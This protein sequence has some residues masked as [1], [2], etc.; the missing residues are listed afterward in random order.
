LLLSELTAAAR[1][2]GLDL[3]TTLAAAEAALPDPEEQAMLPSLPQGAG[4]AE[5]AALPPNHLRTLI[6]QLG[7]EQRRHLAGTPFTSRLELGGGLLRLFLRHEH[8][9]AQLSR[10]EQP[11]VVLDATVNEGLLRAIFPGTP[12]QIERPVI[13]GG[14]RVVQAISRDWAKSTLRGQ[15]R[16]QWYDAVARRI[17]PRRPTLVV[18]TQDTEEDLRR[19]LAGRGHRDVVVAHYRALRGANDYKGFDVILSQVYHPN[20]DALVRDGRALFADDAEALDE[21][22]VTT[23]RRLTDAGGAGWLV[24]VPTFAD[25]RLAALLESGREAEMLQCA[26]RGRPLDHPEAQ[27]TLMFGLPIPGLTPTVICEDEASPQ[28]NGGR[29]AQARDTLA[30]AARALLDGGRR[31]LGADD[32]AAASGASVVTVRKHLPALAGRLGLRLVQ[33]RRAAPLARGGTRLYE[34]QV[35][36]Q[37]GRWAPPRPVHA[38]PERAEGQVASSSDN[39]RDQAHSISCITRLIHRPS[40]LRP[41]ASQPRRLRTSYRSRLCRRPARASDQGRL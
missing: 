21:R 1:A 36:V 40:P 4:L 26:L 15:R 19:A 24:Q 13:A 14:A 34:R 5:F 8:L 35:L 23:E 32:L 31:V 39:T 3:A 28:S 38:E 33:Q 11:K 17:R 12:I 27:I 41:S 29:L 10:P 6:A 37:R 18:C 9:I 25:P 22:V 7:R 16:E 20:L 2:E 30:A